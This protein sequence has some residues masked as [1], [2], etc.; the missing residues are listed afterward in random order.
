LNI[1]FLFLT[2][3]FV[4]SATSARVGR[5]FFVIVSSICVATTIWNK[6]KKIKKRRNETEIFFKKKTIFSIPPFHP[7]FF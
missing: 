2:I 1:F 6:E 5:A 7:F 4:T 3:A